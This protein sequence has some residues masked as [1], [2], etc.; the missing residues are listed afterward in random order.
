LFFTASAA[1]AKQGGVSVK[2]RQGITEDAPI[3]EEVELYAR[4][5]ALVVEID[6]YT[7]G[8]PRL[9]MAVKD[10][11]AIAAALTKKGFEVTLVLNPKSA[12]LNQAFEEF[13]ILK[14][15]N[16]DARLFV[17]FAGHGHSERGEGYLV[18]TDAPKPSKKGLFRLRALSLRRIG[19]FVRLAESKH[20]FAVFDSCFSGTVFDSARAMPPAAVTRAT[21]L[22]VRQFLTSG[23]AG[24]TVSDNGAF[25]ELFIRALSGDEKADANDDGY[26]T[27]SEIGLF[28]TDRV[29]NLTESKQTPRYGKLRDKDW[30]RGDFVFTLP[31]AAPTPVARVSATNQSGGGTTSETA[32]LQQES[33]FWESIKDS[34]DASAFEAYL[35]QFPRGTFAPL[36]RVKLKAL[37]SGNAGRKRALVDERRQLEAERR[38]FADEAARLRREG[39]EKLK[40]DL[41][42]ERRRLA[43]EEAARAERRRTEQSVA[44][45]APA[46][47]S[48]PGVAPNLLTGAEIRTLLSDNTGVYT[49]PRKDLTLSVTFDADGQMRG[50]RE[51]DGRRDWGKWWIEDDRYCRKWD[52]WAKQRVYCF[53]ISLSGETATHIGAMGTKVYDMEL[54]SV[55]DS[56]Q[57]RAG[58]D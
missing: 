52:K 8:W 43:D 17:W 51:E 56:L 31:Q 33:L 30:D 57:G 40:A 44:R 38:R 25:R 22:P 46:A 19:E 26:V 12:A 9:S 49:A 24:Q 10:A 4:S 45:L 15:E 14:G 54:E 58:D 18:P 41:A 5:Y 39:A 11:K 28:L 23:D 29:T 35:S 34:N 3:S 20:A 16:P 32:R 37:K 48:R 50:S 53:S 55:P 27:A 47:R 13:Y 7:H 36:A 2:L 21:T 1:V 6:K 42:A